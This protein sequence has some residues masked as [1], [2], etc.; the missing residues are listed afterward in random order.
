MKVL[1]AECTAEPMCSIDIRSKQSNAICSQ[2]T[3]RLMRLTFTRELLCFA[4]GFFVG[5][6]YGKLKSIWHTINYFN[7]YKQ[8]VNLLHHH[9]FIKII[10]YCFVASLTVMYLNYG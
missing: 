1:E 4:S 7:C 9:G 8:Q 5:L 3:G 2:V 10:I 6:A